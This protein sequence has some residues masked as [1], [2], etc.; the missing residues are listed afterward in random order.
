MVLTVF[1]V[2]EKRLINPVTSEGFTAATK[3][4]LDFILVHI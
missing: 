3:T 2:L 1:N 4:L